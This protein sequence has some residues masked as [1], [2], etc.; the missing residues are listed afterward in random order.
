MC[1]NSKIHH[2]LNTEP[3]I[4]KIKEMREEAENIRTYIFEGTLNSK[5]GQFAMLW[6]PGVDEKPFSIAR[7]Y[8]GEI[9]FTICKVGPMTE[10][11]FEY[12]VGDSVGLRGAFGNGFST[13][14]NKKVVLVGGG[15][16]TAPLHFTA[17]KHADNGCDV[18]MII[19][20]RN[21]NLLIWKD[22]CE[23]SGFRTLIAT[24]DGSAGVKGYTTQILADLLEKEE[25]D[26]VQTCGPEIMMKI[27]GEMC[28]E[29][30]VDCEV[31]VE[32]YMKCGFGICGQCVTESG[33]KMCQTGPVVK[34]EKALSFADFGKFHR[35]PEG[36]IVKW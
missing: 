34:A 1:K 10:K 2:Q 32:R 31:S 12:K 11:L 18:T 35:G 9:W 23:K 17:K 6:L 16:G 15:Y 3:Q 29:K 20:A 33:E 14:Q 7:D 19:G 26:L 21:E 27:I 25:I 5:P 36:Q 13:L 8:D 22:F 24:D 28:I 30:N 4:F